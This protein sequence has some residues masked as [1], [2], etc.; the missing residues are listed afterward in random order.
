MQSLAKVKTCLFTL[1]PIHLLHLMY[2]FYPL[3]LL[4]PFNQAID[5]SLIV[6]KLTNPLIMMKNALR[7]ALNT[8]TV[9]KV[10][11]NNAP[12]NVLLAS[13]NTMWI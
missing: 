11:I 6:L 12:Q 7:N 9:M 10:I 4:Q 13:M 8:I 1:N 3:L 5:V 2:P